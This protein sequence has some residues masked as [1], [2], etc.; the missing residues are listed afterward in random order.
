S[1]VSPAARKSPLRLGNFPSQPKGLAS[2]NYARALYGGDIDL[3]KMI[4]PR[5]ETKL[6]AFVSQDDGRLAKDHNVFRSTGGSIY[7][8]RHGQLVPGGEHVQTV[9]RDRDSGMPL[10]TQPMARDSDYVIDYGGGRLFFKAPI[11]SVAD[12]SF[13]AGNFVS[14]T[15]TLS[16]HPVYVEVDYDY[17]TNDVFGG[18]I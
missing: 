15:A 9:V 3:D 17:Q 6:K 12:A 14:S 18:T 5:A 1:P 2:Y 4:T 7:F 11:P 13:L 8:L 10:V 16:G